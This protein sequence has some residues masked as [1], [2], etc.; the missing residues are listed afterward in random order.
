MRIADQVEKYDIALLTFADGAPKGLRGITIKPNPALAEGTWVVATGNPFF[1]AVDGQSVATLGVISG[2]DRILGREF[3]YGKAIQHD[4][5]VN[6]GNSGG[7][8]WNVK[9]DFIGINGMIS[10]RGTEG[11]GAH[12]TGASFS[13]P[14]EQV[15][16]YLAAMV[17]SKRNAEAGTLGLS[18]ETH[19]DEDGTA[20]GAIVLTVDLRYMEMK[21]LQKG[22]VI[23]R[24]VPRSQSATVIRT[25]S[26]LTNALSMCPEGTRVTV[27]YKRGRKSGSWTGDLKGL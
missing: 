2:L 8:L 3:L 17:D 1:L 21:G 25:A 4:S 18:F 12:N 15:A 22:D 27:F 5:E 26:D 16:R 6:P 23:T 13:I 14:A 10:S 11:T 7:P 24:F 19:T 20:A 9:G